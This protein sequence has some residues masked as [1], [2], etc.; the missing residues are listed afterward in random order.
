[1]TVVIELIDYDISF[2]T[3]IDLIWSA[4]PLAPEV[5]PSE[6]QHLNLGILPYSLSGYKFPESATIYNF[7]SSS[8]FYSE[9]SNFIRLMFL[10]TEGTGT[11]KMKWYRLQRVGF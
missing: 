3:T 2:Q 9:A 4:V 10:T 11:G 7:H 6:A 8:S 5:L 1:M